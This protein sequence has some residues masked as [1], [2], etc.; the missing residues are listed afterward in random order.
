MQLDTLLKT[1]LNFVADPEKAWGEGS[2]GW[3]KPT[4]I[5]LGKPGR[6]QV[7][8]A[9][10]NTAR[11][12]SGAYTP[13]QH[14]E[15]E[16]QLGVVERTGAGTAYFPGNPDSLP[17]DMP[18]Q[19][20]SSC[21]KSFRAC[22]L[23]ADMQCY[24]CVLNSLCPMQ[25]WRDIRCFWRRDIWSMEAFG[26]YGTRNEL[27]FWWHNS[28]SGGNIAHQGLNILQNNELEV[29]KMVFSTAAVNAGCAYYVEHYPRV[30]GETSYSVYSQPYVRRD[31]YGRSTPIEAIE[32]LVLDLMEAMLPS[33][34]LHEYRPRNPIN[35]CY[36]VD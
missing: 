9:D 32:P 14:A 8:Q 31:Q 15:F 25:P 34:M 28:N 35:G 23:G 30:G 24:N 16:R 3:S 1:L 18:K 6:V 33:W 17:I 2:D 26:R 7:E 12:L 20:C 27:T 13:E 21:G 22:Y 4:N 10:R 19:H 11:L 29:T 5:K 36:S